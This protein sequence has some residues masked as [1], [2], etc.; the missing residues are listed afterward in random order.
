MVYDD[1]NKLYKIVPQ[2]AAV[3]GNVTPMLGNMNR[4]LPS[5]FSVQIVPQLRSAARC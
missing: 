4:A 3:R 1:A 2:G 5:G